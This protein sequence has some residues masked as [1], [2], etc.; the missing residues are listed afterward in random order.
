MESL[1]RSVMRGEDPKAVIENYLRREQVYPLP[2]DWQS[3]RTG[4]RVRDPFSGRTGMIE[5]LPPNYLVAGVLVRWDDGTASKE[6]YGPDIVPEALRREQEEP[7]VDADRGGYLPSQSALPDD[8][9]GE[10]PEPD[11][12]FGFRGFSIG[13]RVTVIADEDAAHGRIGTVK[14][15][16]EDETISVDLDEG[17][18]RKF[19]S[20]EL[21]LVASDTGIFTT[22]TEARMSFE[23]WM[24]KIDQ[25][26]GTKTGLSYLDFADMPYRDWYEA[27]ISPS[28]A[29]KR[30]LAAEGF[31]SFESKK[32]EQEYLD[33][34]I[35][36]ELLDQGFKQAGGAVWYN[37]SRGLTVTG[38]ADRWQ[39]HDSRGDLIARGEGVGSAAALG[40]VLRGESLKHEVTAGPLAV[41]RD[42]VSRWRSIGA[43]NIEI[44]QEIRRVLGIM[45]PMETPENIEQILKT[46]SL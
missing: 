22:A 1:I 46:L 24:R 9:L 19:Q 28:S 14:T 36:S 6:V 17:N 7:P 41:A 26:V 23:D 4:M 5:D 2:H 15:L 30:L 43:T 29:A 10:P 35:A 42:I 11:T 21:S 37:A 16:N 38:H 12:L 25:I 40:R 34:S 20:Y 32:Y 39:M 13:D 18:T 45:F 44:R 8:R 33:I 3:P 31:G 27:G